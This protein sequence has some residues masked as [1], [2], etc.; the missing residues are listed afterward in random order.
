M[1]G[2]KAVNENMARATSSVVRDSVSMPNFGMET[3]SDGLLSFRSLYSIGNGYGW[4]FKS[5]K[6]LAT[7]LR[8][9]GQ[10]A[11]W[12]PLPTRIGRPRYAPP[13]KRYRPNDQ[14]GKNPCP[15]DK[16]PPNYFQN[17]STRGKSLVKG[18]KHARCTL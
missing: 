3:G 14:K 10:N 15:N 6:N 1:G 17:P 16:C 11:H 2:E 7:R 8:P 4:N 5:P 12:T 13:V 18:A 9:A